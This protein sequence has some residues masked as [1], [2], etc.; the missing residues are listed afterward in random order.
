M[1]LSQCVSLT[2]LCCFLIQCCLRDQRSQAFNVV[3]WPCCVHAEI[4]TDSQNLLMTLWT[5]DDEIPQ[6]LATVHWETLFLNCKTICSCSCS[7][8]GEICPIL[9]C[10]RLSLLGILL[11]YSIMTFTCFQLTSSPV[12]CSKQVFFKHSS[13]FPVFCCPHP[14]YFGTCCRHPIQNE[15]ISTQK[16]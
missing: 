8:S 6:F 1:F 14:S 2:E 4:S 10:E 16:Q 15:C 3:F 5:E 9:V 11:L 7:Q 12:E 13:T